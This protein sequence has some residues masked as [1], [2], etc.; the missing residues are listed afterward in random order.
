LTS[1]ARDS[2]GNLWFASLKNR[3]QSGEVT[4]LR[5]SK[6]T[7]YIKDSDGNTFGSCSAVFVDK[8]GIVWTH[9]YNGIARFNGRS[10]K[11]FDRTAVSPDLP[12]ANYS[13]MIQDKSG[14]MWFGT[15]GSGLLAYKNNRWYQFTTRNGIPC[16]S[17][18]SLSLD[19]KD[20][21][22]ILTDNG[23]AMRKSDGVVH[24]R[25]RHDF[26]NIRNKPII[27][28]SGNRFYV[29][30][31]DKPKMIQY[32]LLDLRGRVVH[33]QTLHNRKSFIIPE[34]NFNY[35]FG[36]GLRILSITTKG[37]SGFQSKYF[38]KISDIK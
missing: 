12:Y 36:Q 29:T 32:T 26:V 10:W 22:W 5:N 28:Q 21:L 37:N 30:S 27:K 4:V 31:K 6:F 13:Y 34:S 19:S 35:R 16:N 17:I 33:R 23:I 3:Y 2:S 14:T 9:T 20:N 11:L 18:R 25:I 15:P 7:R 8:S 1:I 38:L 24:N